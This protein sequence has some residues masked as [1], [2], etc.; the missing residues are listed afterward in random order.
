MKKICV[1][2]YCDWNNYGSMMQ[3]IGLKTMLTEL[4]YKSI[5]VQD[6]PAPASKLQFSLHICKNPM[7]T[8]KNIYSYTKRK[9]IA[10][11]YENTLNFMRDNIDISY[12]NDYDVLKNNPPY[13]DF[14]I[15]GSD[16]IWRP[17]SCHPV[18]FLDFVPEGKKRI[19][20]AASMGNTN[21]PEN[22]IQVFKDFVNKFDHISVREKDNAECIK[23]IVGKE[24][25]I[26][27]DPAYLNDVEQWRKYEKPYDIKGP[28][29]LLYA[30]YWDKKLNKE[31]KRLHKKTGLPIVAICNGLSRA[32][33]NKKLFDVDPGQFLWLIDH[34]EAV[35]SSSFHGVSLSIIFN[36]KLA[37]VINP[38]LPSRI[39]NI[40]KNLEVENSTIEKVFDA[41]TS[42]Y[43]NTNKLILNQKQKS[44]DYL[45]KVLRDDE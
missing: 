12:Y 39:T 13:A 14:Y 40:L 23:E 5:V 15:A 41:D 21:I 22:K 19:S 10:A 16:Q 30:L 25:Q 7:A 26:H 6:K 31:L 2:T 24:A 29:I 45:K 9:K 38:A 36:K 42:F 1:S 20:Y 43:E 28:Y 11:K 33:A 34:A 17:Q 18:F 32:W 44:I 27:I 8:I 3:T 4:G 35:I 37:A